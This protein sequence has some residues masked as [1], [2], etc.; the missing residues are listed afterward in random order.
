VN[1]VVEPRRRPWLLL[2]TLLLS[3]SA[4]V[5]AS[6][7]IQRL[8]RERDQLQRELTAET[9]RGLDLR[10]QL[11]RVEITLQEREAALAS[12]EAALAEATKPELPVRVSFRPAWMGQ[13]MVATIRNVAD[14]PLNV[15]AEFRDSSASHTREFSLALDAKGSAEIGLA[16]G[17][18]VAPGQSVTVAASGYRSI[19]AFAP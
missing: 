3:L 2:F 16:Q 12:R 11:T 7:A 17:W 10:E 6:F 13:G 15:I 8:Q 9:S 18:T 19:K 4:L 5:V 1:E 14:R